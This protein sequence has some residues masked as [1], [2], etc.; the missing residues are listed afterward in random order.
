MASTQIYL[1]GEA[2]DKIV[3]GATVLAN[4][5]RVRSD[6]AGAPSSSIKIRRAQ[7]FG[8]RRKAMPRISRWSPM[9]A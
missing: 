5:V 6:R 1:S 3:A 9:R 7:G 2:R 8:D 4:A